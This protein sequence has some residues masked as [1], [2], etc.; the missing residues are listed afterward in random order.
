MGPVRV[1]M[2]QG[3]PGYLGRCPLRRALIWDSRGLRDQELNE[4]RKQRFASLAHVVHELKEAQVKWEFLLGRS[5]WDPGSYETS[6]SMSAP[7]NAL[8]R[9]RTL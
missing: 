8:P 3:V 7:S 5:Y 1:D 9:L 4:R 6:S 2:L